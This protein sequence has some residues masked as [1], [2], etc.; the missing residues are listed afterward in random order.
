[1][2]LCVCVSVCACVCGACVCGACVWRLRPIPT[3]PPAAVLASRPPP[4]ATAPRVEAAA[5]LVRVF[6]AT[7]MDAMGTQRSSTQ[8]RDSR[9]PRPASL[10]AAA[11]NIYGEGSASQTTSGD[12]EEGEPSDVAGTSGGSRPRGKT[13]RQVGSGLALRPF[14]DSL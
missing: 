7:A 9:V 11:R 10:M 13:G 2:C 6:S 3:L 4:S 14:E 12:R 5:G 8:P 1:V